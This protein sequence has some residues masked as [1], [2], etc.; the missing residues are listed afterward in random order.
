VTEERDSERFRRTAAIEA[1]T[2]VV[3][4]AVCLVALA[5][6]IP[7]LIMLWRFAIA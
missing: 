1:I 5:I 6:A 4:A 3:V 2:V 7:L